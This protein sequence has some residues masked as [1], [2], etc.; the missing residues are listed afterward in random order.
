M[1]HFLKYNLIGVVNT[2]ISLLVVWVLYQ[3]FHLNL[4][5]ANFLGFVAG[6]INS[7][8]WNRLW[9]FKSEN[10]KR[11][12]TLRFIS[13]FL[14]AYLLNLLVLKGCDI[15]LSDNLA[16]LIPLR[17]SGWISPGYIANILANIVYVLVS[18]SL[19]RFWVFAPEKI[20]NHDF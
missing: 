10:K 13:V 11:T 2:L 9:N 16:N 15:Y 12:E 18:Y 3:C 14:F 1:I 8:C 5:L 19:F 20:T 6:A 4:V 17:I 7:Y